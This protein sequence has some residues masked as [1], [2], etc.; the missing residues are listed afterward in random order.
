MAVSK[1]ELA[2][3]LARRAIRVLH[4]AGHTAY[5]VGGCVRD[6]LMDVPAKD[7]DVATSAPPQEVMR[8]FPGSDQVGAHFGVVL[9]KQPD[10]GASVEVATFRSDHA[11]HDGRHPEGVTFENDPR[12]DALR[13]DF[14][15]NAM[16]MEPF[17]GAVLD[18]STGRQDLAAK[19]IRAV[20]NPLDRFAEDHLR[21]LRAVRFAARLGFDIEP[22]TMAAI[23]ALAPRISTIS[24]ERVREE[25]TRIF[26]E[27]AARRGTELLE[28]SGLLVHVLAEAASP[29]SSARL[30]S[31]AEMDRGGMASPTL[32]VAVL[33][34]GQPPE[35]LSAALARL[36]FSSAQCAR[37][38]ALLAASWAVEG[39]AGFGLAA[40]K[41]TLRLEGF[42]EHL[43]FERIR[44]ARTNPAPYEFA[45]RKLAEFPPEV[46]NPPRLAT[47]DDLVAMGL[48]PGPRFKQILEDLET[49]QLEDRIK[50]RE[51][52]LAM[53][54]E[55][56]AQT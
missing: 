20:G 17:S 41:R 50:T 48:A 39:L 13:R 54:R 11:Y 9:V 52:A 29:V 53:M 7:F 26:T 36:R 5:L 24:A 10:D 28:E 25:L 38:G 44:H 31:L 45:R 2:S 51:E 32:A 47:G 1:P 42:D 34:E 35:A 37:V 3:A 15:I 6:L 46:L 12:Q 27:G 43:E 18:F 49:G 14:T 21:M 33:L 40:Q 4:E 30:A 8:L 22:E 19:L 55:A 16:M 56:A 23:Q